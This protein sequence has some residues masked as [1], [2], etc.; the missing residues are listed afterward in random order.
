MSL[1]RLLLPPPQKLELDAED[2][3]IFRAVTYTSTDMLT[4]GIMRSVSANDAP[5]A[6]RGSMSATPSDDVRR[7]G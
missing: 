4:R 1:Y 2:E 3:A 6:V 7:R 5:Q